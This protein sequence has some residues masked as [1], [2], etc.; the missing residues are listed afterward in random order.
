MSFCGFAMIKDHD[1]NRGVIGGC[2]VG[3]STMWKAAQLVG[4]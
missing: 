2:V 3:M 1:E 4:A